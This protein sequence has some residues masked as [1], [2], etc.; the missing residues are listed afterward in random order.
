M[1]N[2]TVEKALIY[3]ITKTNQPVLW[4]TCMFNPKEY[5]L[6]KQNSWK[7]AKTGG[8]NTLPLEF[9]NGQ[10]AKLQMQLFFDTYG[11]D[12][13]V[14]EHTD[15]VWELMLVDPDLKDTNS[16]KGR[17]PVVRFQWGGNW[18]FDAVVASITQKFTLFR[19]TGDP[20]RATLD[21]AF[22][23][24]LDPTQLAGQN[25]TSGG[26]GGERRWVVRAG[27]TLLGIAFQEYGDPN[28]WREIAQANRLTDVRRLMPGVVL[29]IP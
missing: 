15:K 14:R 8:K 24:I 26:L 29:L 12:K 21:V 5:T 9:D 10:P 16:E 28:R 11:T 22:Q 13:D 3:K 17:P 6:S 18:S 2:P 19:A 4:V 23:Q 20:V 1:P 7:P 25:P 27:D